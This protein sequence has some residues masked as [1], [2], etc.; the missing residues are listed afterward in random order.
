M[1]RK[2]SV[3]CWLVVLAAV[4]MGCE[5]RKSSSLRIAVIPKGSTHEFW[6]SVHTGA[7][8]AATELGI[9]LDWK[10]PMKE[11]DRA[12]QIDLVEQFITDNVSAIALAPLDDAALVKPVQEAGAKKIPVVIFDS[13]LQGEVGKDF[14]SFVATDNQQGGRLGGQ[15]MVKLLGGHGKVV[16]LRYSEGSASTMAR[17]AGFLEVMDATPG[18]TVISKNRYAGVTSDEAY[19]NSTNM[20]DLLKTADGIFCPN[21]SSTAGMML[22]LR[23][24]GLNGKVKVVGFDTSQTLIDYLR[25]GDVDAL[26]AQNPVKMGYETVKAATAAVR[27]QSVSPRIDTG[28]R[29]ITK[30]DLDNPEVKA[31]LGI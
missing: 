25:K 31:L 3:S 30:A 27:G 7:E 1:L 6:K 10:G 17:E 21:E 15:T 22:T 16:L 23:D 2:M 11:N 26:V 4:M 19:K 29:T 12:Q 5:Q 24:A 9:E 28:V 8:R 20:I 14:V 18:I 13:A